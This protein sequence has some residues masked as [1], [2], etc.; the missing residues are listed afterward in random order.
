MIY[1][2]KKNLENINYISI[3]AFIKFNTKI[4]NTVKLLIE[5][6][7]IWRFYTLVNPS[8]ITRVEIS[9]VSYEPL[10]DFEA[11][12]KHFKPPQPL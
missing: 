8:V 4:S 11:H 9:R 6:K 7:E 12:L 3:I 2:L 5:R 1:E 10:G